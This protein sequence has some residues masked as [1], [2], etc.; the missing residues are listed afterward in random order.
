[1]L[2]MVADQP[3][4][5]L[6]G[7]GPTTSLFTISVRRRN[8]LVDCWVN[9][10][11]EGHELKYEVSSSVLRLVWLLWCLVR[12]FGNMVS[13]SAGSLGT[14]KC[15]SYRGRNLLPLNDNGS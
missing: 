6:L 10:V 8:Y 11:L 2:A 14:C 7:G 13:V 12:G 3:L 15:R 4:V 5:S 1:L 9:L